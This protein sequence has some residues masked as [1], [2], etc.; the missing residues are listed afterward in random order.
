MF[1]KPK[2]L[3]KAY[4]KFI[5]LPTGTQIDGPLESDTLTE[6][7]INTTSEVPAIENKFVTKIREEIEKNLSDENFSVEQLSQNLFMSYSQL[8]R[9]LTAVIGSTPNQFIKMLR[10]EK[11]SILLK[12]TDDTIANIASQCGF[13]D[14]GYFGK[15]FRQEYGMTPHDWRMK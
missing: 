9:K 5:G 13:S 10:I 2:L 1:D 4:S 3:Q 15:V 6:Q 14:A 8:H 12:T 7:L 11:A